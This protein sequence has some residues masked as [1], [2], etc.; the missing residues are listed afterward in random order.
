V[1][2]WTA[3]LA[4]FTVERP[5][6]AFVCLF[7]AIGYLEGEERLR[8]CAR[9]VAAAV[10]PGGALVIEPWLA[11]EQVDPGRPSLDTAEAPDLRIAR[12]CVS[13]LDGDVLVVPFT[14]LVARRG[15]PVETFTE[16]HRLWCAPTALVVAAFADAGFDARFLPGGL[17]G[18]GLVVGT[19]R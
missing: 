9:A 2:L 14:W 16:V 1:T 19:R 11:P 4:D 18:R 12:A 17:T 8:S 6:D 10:R 15:Q 3:D 7:S 5:V 13:E